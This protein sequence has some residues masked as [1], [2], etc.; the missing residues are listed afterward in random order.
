MHNTVVYLRCNFVKLFLPKK[1]K[2]VSG[3]CSWLLV[4]RTMLCAGLSQNI[5]WNGLASSGQSIT[6]CGRGILVHERKFR[7]VLSFATVLTHCTEFCV[8]TETHGTFSALYSR[9]NQDS[10]LPSEHE[11]VFVKA[12]RGMLEE[13]EMVMIKTY[14]KFIWE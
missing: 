9:K 3:S 5:H 1:R 12:V 8:A 11:V 2:K 14:L 7:G 13:G 10:N 4:N 6:S